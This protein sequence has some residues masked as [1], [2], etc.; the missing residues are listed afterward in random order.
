MK[1]LEEKILREGKV[2]EGN[3]FDKI[4]AAN[5][6]ETG[7][8]KTL[9]ELRDDQKIDFTYVN[10]NLVAAYEALI[11]KMSDIED[12]E[13]K[14]KMRQRGVPEETIK[15]IFEPTEDDDYYDDDFVFSK[16]ASIGGNL[17]SL[18]DMR[19]KNFQSLFNGNKKLT[20]SGH[21]LL[22]L[23]ETQEDGEEMLVLLMP[24]MV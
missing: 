2:L 24:M 7:M 20:K 6:I 23:P 19:E 3:K 21:W 15:H 8:G 22:S 18:G 13:Q 9:E 10:S 16:K 4:A 11:S 1:A 5:A 14:E 17:S 12:E